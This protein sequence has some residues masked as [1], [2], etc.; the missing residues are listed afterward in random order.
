MPEDEFEGQLIVDEL[1]L[2]VI[3]LD[4]LN[5][6]KVVTNMDSID[7][8]KK[9]TV[10][11]DI[12]HA[13]NLVKD[14]YQLYAKKPNKEEFVKLVDKHRKIKHDNMHNFHQ[15]IENVMENKQFEVID[16]KTNKKGIITIKFKELPQEDKKKYVKSIVEKIIKNI[17]KD[18]MR[19]LFTQSILKLNGIEELKQVDKALD[20]EDAVVEDKQGCFKFVVDGVDLFVVG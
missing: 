7:N 20:K 19:K 8:M 15:D 18:S 16:K 17:S 4:E 1:G 9:N 11:Y 3:V 2:D 5:K 13:R 6:G 12:L 14:I 10:H